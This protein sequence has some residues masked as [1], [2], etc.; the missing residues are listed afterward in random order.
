MQTVLF[1]FGNTAGE[2]EHIQ[3]SGVIELPLVVQPQEQAV[4]GEYDV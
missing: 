2:S 4:C 3:L 1:M